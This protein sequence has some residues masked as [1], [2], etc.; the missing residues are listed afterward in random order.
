[1]NIR[2]R[3]I[4][5]I[6]NVSEEIHVFV[7]ALWHGTTRASGLSCSIVESISDE[8]FRRIE[9]GTD[10]ARSRRRIR[11]VILPIGATEQ[12]GPHLATGMD[13]FTVES[14][15][16]EAEPLLPPRFRLWCN[17]G[18]A[19]RFVPPSSSFSAAPS[20]SAPRPT[21]ACFMS[22]G[23][24]WLRMDLRAIFLLNGH[25]GNHE[26][27]QLAVATLCLS[28]RFARP[29]ARTGTWLGRIGWCGCA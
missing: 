20:L 29:P 1:M 13:Y 5:L 2:E 22:C 15:A 16:R 23:V 18:S 17:A 6:A 19:L 27:A 24:R 10:T 25:G 21:I 12:H 3:H 14:I 8:T 28:T 4:H 11:C 9:P 26:L 7:P